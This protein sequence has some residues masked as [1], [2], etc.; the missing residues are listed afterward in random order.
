MVSNALAVFDPTMLLNGIYQVQVVATDLEDRT[1]YSEVTTLKVDRNLK[2]GNFTISFNDLSVPVAGIPI[3]IVRT[4]DSRDH[5]TND[6]GVGWS[7][8]V[9]NVRLQKNRSIGPSWFEDVDP[10]FGL[11]TYFIDPVNER[12]LT[13]TLANGREYKFTATFYTNSQFGAPIDSGTVVYQPT[14]DTYATLQSVEG[15]DVTVAIA[16]SIPGTVD[17]FD[18]A[19]GDFFNPTLF[20]MTT[21]E[22]EVY[23]I[24]EITGLQSMS[25]RN[26]NTLLF[27]TN[28]VFWTN[29]VTGG[30]STGVTFVRDLQGRISQILDPAGN[31]L[32]YTYGT[33]GSLAAFT[34]RNTNTTTFAYTNAAFPNYLT[35]IT[36]PRGVQAVRTIYDDSGRM[37]QQIDGAGNVIDFTHDLPNNAEITQD[38]MGYITVNEYDN[39]G[40]IIKTIDPLGNVTTFTYDPTDN[41]L[42]QV[43]AL[44]NTNSYT[45]DAKG[46]KLS[47]TDPLGNTTRYTYG[48]LRELTSTTTPRGFTTT[49]TYDPDTGNLIQERDPLGNVTSYSYDGQGN[50]LTRTDV[51]GNVMSNRYDNLG[52]ITTMATIDAVRGLL[53]ATTFTYDSN[54]N[55]LSKSIQRTT[56]N[57]PQVLTTSYVY[58]NQN[59]LV[60]TINP[61][62]STNVTIYALGLNKTAVE[63][64]PLGRQTLYYYDALGNLTNTVYADGTSESQGYDADNRQI[65]SIDQAGNTTFYTNDALGRL[66]ITVYPDQTGETNYFDAVGRIFAKSDAKGNTTLFGFDAGGR[67][68]SV[69]NALNQVTQ[70]QYDEDGNRLAMIDALGRTNVTVYDALDRPVQTVFADGT[71]VVT[72][73]DSIGRRSS[74]QD[75]AGNVT[76]F[77][78]DAIGR[79]IS[80]TNAFGFVTTYTYDELGRQ[81][82]QNDSNNH[83]TT[84]EYDSM[85]R[86]VKRTLPAGQI[87][88]YS[89][90]LS[91]NLTNET[92]FDGYTT[93]YQYD[94][95]NRLLA[96]VPDPRRGESSVTFGYNV[97][98]LR[99]N[100]IDA[101]GSTAY[102]YDIR[103]RVVQKTKSWV[104]QSS[105]VA[106]NYGYDANG[107]LTNI[108]SSDPNGVNVAY[109]YDALNRLAA[110][111]D[112]RT[113]LSSYTYDTVGNL[114]GY[115][116]PN[117]VH[118]E[119]QYDALN[120]LTN[121]ASDQL[122]T[123]IA[124]Y[125]YAVGPTGIR[126]NAMEQLFASALNAQAKT[127]NRVYTYDSIYRLTGETINGTPSSGS[128]NYN[129]D[130]VGNR[131]S[132]NITGL[133]LLPQSF[134]FDANDRL[135]SDSY[136]ANGN[137]LIGAGFGQNQPDGYDFEN[138]LISRQTPGSVVYIKYDG[139]GNRVCKTV[140]TATNTTTT[141]YVVDDLNPSG[142][143]QVLEEHT[144]INSQPTT[145]NC[146]FTYGHMLMSQDRFN[147]SLWESSFYG[148]DGHNNVRYLT[149]ANAN[150][151]DTYDYDAF[152]NLLAHTGVTVNNY[153]FTGQ[154]YDSDLGLYFLRA[155]YQ[156]TDTGRFWTMDSYEGMNS[157]PLTLHKYLYAND[158]PANSYDPSGNLSL[159]ELTGVE[160]IDSIIG[161]IQKAQNVLRTINRVKGLMDMIVGFKQMLGELTT[162]VPGK[163]LK[164][165]IPDANE[166]S[167]EGFAE[168]FVDL[169]LEGFADASLNWVEGYTEGLLEGKKID[170]YLI[171]LPTLIGW[172]REYDISTG[173]EIGGKPLKLV[174]GAFGK[175]K[176]GSIM[177]VGVASGGKNL[178]LMRMDIGKLS[179]N[180][181]KATGGLKNGE[182]EVL[183][184]S[185]YHMHVY[186]WDNATGPAN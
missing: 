92:D 145:I 159:V 22:G 176:I 5:T 155:R 80:V 139:D 85:G 11:P 157:D 162:D 78:Y 104:G 165:I 182:L 147:G 42:Q 113:G 131:L 123:A 111:N 124:N 37:I 160:E 27:S 125:A 38:R 68:T 102:S 45:Y 26:G 120:R 103:N 164:S 126:T 101:S 134:T 161:T 79:L 137:T 23:I 170:A 106:L 65:A 39:D 48:P 174:A 151:T 15:D 140:T 118:T 53:D 107:D 69:T 54:G 51:L 97:L 132:R 77:G 166:L 100:M 63:F 31:A 112:A 81:I 28:G 110:V 66:I 49:N 128:A 133:P 50:P 136:D 149:D 146:V 168:A 129:Y 144:S 185:L 3:Q 109:G 4:Y 9:R 121:I 10:G 172:V 88:T 89:Y 30:P 87:E 43:D 64:D 8:D 40:N 36:D 91:G 142:Y 76:R 82:S 83:T 56:P 184:E 167:F 117:F 98:G 158:D 13:V 127:I 2:I 61:D 17:L 57:G 14:P 84:F 163:L 94:L 130:P 93:T 16:N 152:G 115:T 41:L 52:H 90:D 18:A 138:R 175:D 35:G 75:Q 6:F 108:A 25:D 20:K 141:F 60:E 55:R 71:S 67:N 122:G 116:Y 114:Q 46:N 72:I 179:K 34:D 143:A 33:N 171:Y 186:K 183:K 70:Y 105:R 154:Q 99:T 7:I 29:T 119:Y 153:L 19:T 180:H 73:L 74:Q 32:N 150:V 62:G 177:G 86:R 1:A 96:K 156:N 44:G 59:R 135:N 95:L 181:G 12:D 173:T 21:E 58:D 178:Q 169:S 148:Y 47:G 24:D